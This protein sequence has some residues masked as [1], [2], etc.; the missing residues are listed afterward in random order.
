MLRQ[1]VQRSE[2]NF[3]TSIL[4]FYL[5]ESIEEK[6]GLP[7]LAQ[8]ATSLP[9]QHLS[10]PTETNYMHECLLS[11]LEVPGFIATPPLLRPRGDTDL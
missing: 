10:F 3:I 5:D 2:N 8:A 11:I 9:H 7:R 6:L 1:T 4:S